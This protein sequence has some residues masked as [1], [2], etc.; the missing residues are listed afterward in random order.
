MEWLAIV[1]GVG[2][3]VGLV[4]YLTQPWWGRQ[5][6]D[7]LVLAGA[8]TGSG[9]TPVEQREAILTA[10]RDLDFDYEVA[11]ITEE[12]YSLLRPSLLAEAAAVMSQT[13][14]RETTAEPNLDDWIEA[15]ILAVRRNL[16]SPATSSVQPD[17]ACAACGRPACSSDVYCT[18]CGTRLQQDCPEC[19]SPVRTTDRFC[20][21]CG[22]ELTL[23]LSG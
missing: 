13:P 1:M 19:G 12:D 9:P 15:Q 2:V 23:A 16:H 14:I 3:A 6:E 11:K 8:A 10:L 21:G 4:A 5:G 18:G 17:L 22:V 7:K 20:A